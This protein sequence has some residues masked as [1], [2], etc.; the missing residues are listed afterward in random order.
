MMT[1]ALILCA[2]LAACGG[3]STTPATG[4]GTTPPPA[5]DTRTA[6]E[7]RLDDACGAV[8]KRL[9][10]CALDDARAR[11]AAGE[12]TQAEYDATTAPALLKANSQKWHDTCYRPDRSSR[13]VRVLEVCEQQETECDPLVACL[14]NL[15][16]PVTAPAPR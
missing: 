14:E 10:L 6:F 16:T 7:R 3:G 11:L 15:N 8:G 5:T 12:T 9:T 13:Q 2:T 1:R 4:G